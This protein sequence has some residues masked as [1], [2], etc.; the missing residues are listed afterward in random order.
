MNLM[1]IIYI[2]PIIDTEGPVTDKGS[3]GL[4]NT[5]EEID[6]AIN[7]INDKSFRF[8]YCDKNKNPII[9]NFFIMDWTGFKTNPVKRDVGYHHIYDH[10]LENHL[11]QE[12]QSG[13]N[14]GIYWHY[15]HPPLSGVGNEW[16]TDWTTSDEYYNILNR[17]IIDRN[18]FPYVF[19]SGGTI[20]TNDTSNWLEN[21][22]PFDFSNRSPKSLED[23]FDWSKASNDWS[24]YHPSKHNYQ[25]NG[26]MN[27]VIARSIDLKT[28]I[29]TFDKREIDKAKRKYEDGKDC[30]ISFFTHDYRKLIDDLDEVLN[31]LSNELEG[32]HWEFS[33]SKDAMLKVLEI[34]KSNKFEIRL[35][36]EKEIIISSTK[37]IFGPQPYF[38]ILNKKGI[39]KR[40][41]LIN[42]DT[43]YWKIDSD[44][45]NF[46]DIKII[47]VAAND[48]TGN[49]YVNKIN[50]E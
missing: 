49:T 35:E 26:D 18:W 43:N 17:K 36:I 11:T 50:F 39:Y 13:Y 5:W 44:R 14:D 38:V 27:R 15:H 31:L 23:L 47:G 42:I 32:Y 20:E 28:Y 1:P 29:G 34:K 9:L 12:H 30:I 46:N 10:Y 19:R 16:N 41:D 40:L 22:I 4:L 2:V 21:W 33:N 45:I 6:D 7:E 25:A 3:K 48:F 37:K 24:I 8:K